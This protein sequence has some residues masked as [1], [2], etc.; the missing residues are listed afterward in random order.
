MALLRNM[1]KRF[2]KLPLSKHNTSVFQRFFRGPET[3]PTESILTFPAVENIRRQTLRGGDNESRRFP[4]FGRMTVAD[5]KK[6]MKV[7][8]LEK[9]KARLREDTRNTVSYNEFRRSC[10]DACGNED[11]GLEFAKVLDEAGVVLVFG[12]VVWLHPSQVAKSIESM[13]ISQ[14]INIPN[15]E[16]K[17]ELEHLEKQ[18]IEI[19]KKAHKL[20]RRE[21][22]FG[23][24]YLM[25]QTI[26]FMRL[27][28]WE[29]SWDVMEPIC[30]FTASL[31]FAF[32]YAFFLLTSTEPSFEGYYQ[33][34][35]KTKQRT[36]MKARGFDVARYNRLCSC[37]S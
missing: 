8:M 27:T 19:D 14:Q 32:T 31:H 26:G 30:F 20:V 29:L 11:L 33:T 16:R 21:L 18:K 35:F 23:L 24:G 6:V 5:M 28:F 15:E 13:M 25:A 1:P 36:L 4:T 12:N 22:Y 2:Y 34:R 10:V 7:A 37:G 9:V 3:S 17:K